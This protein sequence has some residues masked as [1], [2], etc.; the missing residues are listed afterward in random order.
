M[1]RDK[2]GGSGTRVLAQEVGGIKAMAAGDSRDRTLRG[3]AS[4]FG[5]FFAVLVWFNFETLS[6]V[7]QDSL[8]LIL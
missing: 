5:P 3:L 7:P 6:G 8:K 4:L 1:Y 2:P